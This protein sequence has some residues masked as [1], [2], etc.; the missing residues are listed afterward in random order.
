MS[1]EVRTEAGLN[2]VP[3]LNA[4]F[5][6][7]CEN[8]SSSP[9]DKCRV[10]GSHSLTSLARVLGGTLRSQKPHPAGYHAKYSVE[11]TAKVQEIPTTDLNLLIELLARLA[12]VGGA[13]ESL[14]LNVEPVI[15]SQ[16]VLS[17]A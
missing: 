5:C 11:I 10:C 2:A 7:N 13:V 15:D 9:H 14:H 6:V 12:E 8:I 4:V 17:A 1:A 3:L 16:A